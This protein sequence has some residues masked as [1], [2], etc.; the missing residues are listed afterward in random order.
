GLAM[1]TFTVA[2][3]GFYLSTYLQEA[4]P[5]DPAWRF[6]ENQADVAVGLLVSTAGAAGVALGG[7]I[8]DKD[9]GED[10]VRRALRVCGVMAGRAALVT[11][12]AVL[13]TNVRAFFFLAWVGVTLAF[14][15]TTPINLALMHAVPPEARSASM[16]LS[17]IVAHLL[18]DVPA[19]VWI[20]WVS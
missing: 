17:L 2:G 14:A 16:A 18:G 6:D 20:G 13:V 11:L 9:V 10:V 8:L 19:P 1:Y 5:C 7:V 3:L 12:A 4:K 15:T